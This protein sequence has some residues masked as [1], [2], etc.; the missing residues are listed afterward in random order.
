MQLDEK[1][2]QFVSTGSPVQVVERLLKAGAKPDIQDKV[3]TG[4]FD[5][6]YLWY[7]IFY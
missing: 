3:R 7:Y 5:D 4:P 2:K 1:V 6:P